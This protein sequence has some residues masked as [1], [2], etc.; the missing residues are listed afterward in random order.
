MVDL[1]SQLN[2]ASSVN[3][4]V[5]DFNKQKVEDF[6]KQLAKIKKNHINE[7]NDLF[8]Q[9]EKIIAE[10][11]LSKKQYETIANKNTQ[12][13]NLKNFLE[14]KIKEQADA[15]DELTLSN[16]ELKDSIHHR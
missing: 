8:Q 15:I 6:N 7:K 1:S 12:L 11:K 14:R 5:E 2:T 9:I 10:N 4:K 3:E 16:Q 13:A